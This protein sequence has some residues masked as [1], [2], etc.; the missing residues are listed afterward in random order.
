[1]TDEQLIKARNTGKIP[2]K[3]QFP[4]ECKPV[5]Y[6]L[7]WDMNHIKLRFINSG[8]TFSEITWEEYINGKKNTK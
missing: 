2:F 5:R 4:E 8:C 6:T 3:V 1:M 7:A